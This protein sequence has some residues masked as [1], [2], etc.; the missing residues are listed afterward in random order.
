MFYHLQKN[1]IK[2]HKK[3]QNKKNIFTTSYTRITQNTN[4]ELVKIA[5][6]LNTSTGLKTKLFIKRK[7]VLT[8]KFQN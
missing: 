1:S 5:K 8:L 7:N 2:Q 4:Q 3:Y 6:F